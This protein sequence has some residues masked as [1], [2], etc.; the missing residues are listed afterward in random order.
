MVD[1]YGR[2]KSGVTLTVQVDA[3]SHQKSSSPI[4]SFDDLPGKS[5]NSALIGEI[6]FL[7]GRSL[8]IMPLLLILH[9]NETRMEN[10]SR[11]VGI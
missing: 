2:G 9:L 11:N 1:L 5:V 8:F 7:N 4:T 6:F 3:Y 10:F